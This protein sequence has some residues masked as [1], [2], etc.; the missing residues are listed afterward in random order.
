MLEGVD[1]G[2]HKS[3]GQSVSCITQPRLAGTPCY[4]RASWTIIFLL[5][6]PLLA[7]RTARPSLLSITC[8][9]LALTVPHTRA[10]VPADVHLLCA[11]HARLFLTATL[12]ITAPS[13]H[14][15]LPPNM[16]STTPL[17]R[18]PVV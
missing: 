15:S 7:L 16:C 11:V 9:I 3:E 14:A 10:S 18:A 8:F 13:V 4:D 5:Y 2:I 12:C 6:S 1:V 17:V